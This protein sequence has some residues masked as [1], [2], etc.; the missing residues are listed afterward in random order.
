[1]LF[2]NVAKRHEDFLRNVADITADLR[3]PCRSLYWLDLIA[4]SAIGYSALIYICVSRFTPLTLLLGM[5]S[6]L[7]LYRALCFMHEISHLPPAAL[8]GFR[9][10]WNLLVG[11]PLLMPS[12]LYQ[13]AHNQH[14]VRSRYGTRDDP[15]YLPL[16]YRS[17]RSNLLFLVVAPL[18]PIALLIRHILLVPGSYLH[19]KLRA[20]L[21]SRG[22][23]LAINPEFRRAPPTGKMRRHW[24]LW[25]ALTFLFA[26]LLAASV[27]CHLVTLK[28]LLLYIV[29]LSAAALIN[30]LRTV[31]SHLWESD[32]NEMTLVE[33]YL[34]SVTVP[35]PAL[36]PAIWA[37]VGLRYHAIHHLV[38]SLPYHS[39]G[40]AHRR[41]SRH[42]VDHHLL[43]AADHHDVGGLVGRLIR[44]KGVIRTFPG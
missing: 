43:H 34:D 7:A 4:S 20:L 9:T 8:P 6:S 13:G 25:E 33:Q 28:A 5:I 1:M 39:L 36:L 22:S 15:D 37:P 26:T 19:P 44:P 24:T 40:T 27:I 31:V 35:P 42:L 10:V 41:L 21:V 38:P 3:R 32:G 30:Q 29:V 12:F 16:S 14:H 23:A 11:M 18:L 2:D 17:G